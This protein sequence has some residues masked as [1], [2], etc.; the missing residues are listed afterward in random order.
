[1]AN[2]QN[3]IH[4]KKKVADLETDLKGELDKFYKRLKEKYSCEDWL[5]YMRR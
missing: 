4:K 3:N 1:M 2:I 5:D